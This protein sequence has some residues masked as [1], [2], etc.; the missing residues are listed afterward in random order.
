MGATLRDVSDYLEERE[1]ILR[2]FGARPQTFDILRHAFSDLGKRIIGEM[3]IARETAYCLPLSTELGPETEKEFLRL[4]E[5][6]KK[7]EEL[8]CR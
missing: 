5:W 3:G 1:R 4:K 2:I 6:R 7:V 8:V